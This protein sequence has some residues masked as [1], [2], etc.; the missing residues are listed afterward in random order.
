MPAPL[1]KHYL[2]TDNSLW[3]MLSAI[4]YLILVFVYT[5]L[6]KVKGANLTA[7]YS[8]LKVSAILLTLMV[9]IF[10]FNSKL[11]IRSIIGI[12][13]AIASVILLSMKD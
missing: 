13:L 5:L 10:L 8:I 1:V 12:I 3:L 7:V 2:K 11:S 6:F 4:S 9:D